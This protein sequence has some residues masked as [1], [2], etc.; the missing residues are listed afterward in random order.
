[1]SIIA[2]AAS[3]Y[4]LRNG[5]EFSMALVAKKSGV[6]FAAERPNAT[7]RHTARWHIEQHRLGYW[8]I[9]LHRKPRADG[10]DAPCVHLQNLDVHGLEWASP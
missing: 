5:K 2:F 8:Q 10:F 3:D 6:G 4:T 1:M 9:N 7:F